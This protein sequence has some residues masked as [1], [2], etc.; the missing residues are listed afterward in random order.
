M[1]KASSDVVSA[2]EIRECLL[3]L[4]A[5]RHDGA[6]FCPSEAARQLSGEWR[7]LMDPVRVQAAKLVEDGLL[8]CMQKGVVADPVSAHG[9]IRLARP[10]KHDEMRN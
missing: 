5:G 10:G 9:P 8:V 6:T 4:A 1:K 2:E 3:R 7:P